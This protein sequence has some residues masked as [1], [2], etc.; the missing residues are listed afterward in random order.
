MAT[1]RR[2]QD[3]DVN[4]LA[5]SLAF[6]TVLS[7]VPLLAVSLSVF[8]ALGGLETLFSK[9]EPFILKNFVEAS[10][11]QISKTIHSS[12]A[13]VHSGTLGI[14]GSIA[15][16]ASSTKLFHDVETSV[17]R[18]W[19]I[20]T[21]RNIF[22]RIVVYWV[23]MFMGPLILAAVVGLIGSKDV[24]LIKVLPK[25]GILIVFAFV[26]FL[27]IYKFVPSVKVSWRAAL[28]SSLIATCGVGI[29]QSFY[30]ELTKNILRL[31]KIYG[32]L[33]SIPIFLLWILVL[34]WVCLLGAALCA[35]LDDRPDPS[36]GVS[37]AVE[38]VPLEG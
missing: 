19:R 13:R 22:R 21:S 6:T 32:S 30:T 9:V 5:G 12:I 26:A 18:V 28:L 25:G 17:H 24:N 11:V 15:L 37:V 29:F 7:L 38:D 23:V 10:G 33:A 2:V 4:F 27:S 34:W 36:T 31:N 35:I 1:W 16:L 3:A 8:N 20:G 14:V